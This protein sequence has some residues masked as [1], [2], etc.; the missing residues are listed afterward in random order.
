MSKVELATPSLIQ[1]VSQQPESLTFAS[2][3]I[4]QENAFPSVVDGLQKRHPFELGGLMLSGG[5]GDPLFHLINRDEV[6]RYA[7]LLGHRSVRVTELDGTNIPVLG[8]A[9]SG[10]T[11]DF[12]YLDLS[13][14]VTIPNADTLTGSPWTATADAIATISVAGAGPL[15]APGI[16]RVGSAAGA[17]AGGAYYAS[18]V[19][20]ATSP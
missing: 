12:S 6:E 16:R 9:T 8:P 2:Q 1:G 20:L 5:A 10:Y 11:P 7:V 19:V 3:A 18:P 14:P 13:T 17:A 15:G 4:L